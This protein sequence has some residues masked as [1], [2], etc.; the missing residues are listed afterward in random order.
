MMS[1]AVAGLACRIRIP[2]RQYQAVAVL[3]RDADHVIRLLHRDAALSVDVEEFDT[4]Q[5]AEEYR[6]RLARF[7]NLPPLTLAGAP[8]VSAEAPG[9]PQSR[10][11]SAL[12]RMRRPR[13][14][15]RRRTGRVMAVRR[16]EGRELIARD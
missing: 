1:R 7:L 6:D 10:R 14:L 11:R 16:I 12:L 8:R 9:V 4:F 5:T 15:M 3:S 2:V 13:F